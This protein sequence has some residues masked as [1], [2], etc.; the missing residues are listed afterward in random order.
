MSETT[1]IQHNHIDD[2]WLLEAIK[3]Q[4]GLPSILVVAGIHQRHREPSGGYIRRQRNRSPQSSEKALEF[5]LSAA[6]RI[7]FFLWVPNVS[8]FGRTRE[9]R[10]CLGSTKTRRQCTDWPLPRAA[11]PARDQA[12]IEDQHCWAYVAR[13]AAPPHVI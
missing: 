5:L 7:L 1:V 9:M 2:D 10:L 8:E 4:L 11:R 12:Y 3:W 6:F 13:A